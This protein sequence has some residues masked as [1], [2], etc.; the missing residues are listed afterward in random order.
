MEVVSSALVLGAVGW[1]GKVMQTV[2][3]RAGP[4]Q[5]T[6]FW[7]VREGFD[8]EVVSIAL[9]LGLAGAETLEKPW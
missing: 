6:S 7:S 4:L 3:M 8:L 2:V 5:G 9:V 1:S